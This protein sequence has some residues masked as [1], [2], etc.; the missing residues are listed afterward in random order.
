MV[1]G[2]NI[3]RYSDIVYADLAPA[4]GHEQ[5]KRRPLIVVSNDDFNRHSTMTFICPVTSSDNGYFLHVDIGEVKAK[6]SD[7][8]ITGFAA[9]EQIKAL[10]LPARNAQLLGRAPDE[11]MEK[12]SE[13][14]QMI[15]LRDDQMLVPNTYV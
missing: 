7:E 4:A 12:I 9:V 2:S 5:N 6:Y 8:L 1:K 11:V 15:L 10:D 13:L 3:F 14:A